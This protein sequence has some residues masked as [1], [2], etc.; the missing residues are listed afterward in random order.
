MYGILEQFFREK[1]FVGLVADPRQKPRVITQI[2]AHRV[3][4]A[5]PGAG[6]INVDLGEVDIAGQIPPAARV[7][8]NGGVILVCS[9][10]IDHPQQ[11]HRSNPHAVSQTQRRRRD[12]LYPLENWFIFFG[13][14]GNLA[15]GKRRLLCLYIGRGRLEPE[16]LLAYL[17][18]LL[19]RPLQIL[20]LDL[21][22]FGILLWQR[23]QAARLELRRNQRNAR[24]KGLR[25]KLIQPQ[26]ARHVKPG[27]MQKYRYQQAGPD[28]FFFQH[29]SNLSVAP[30]LWTVAISVY[31]LTIILRVSFPQ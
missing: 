24:A 2:A 13:T 19:L 3:E 22:R 12:H 21:G 28:D 5:A 10:Q 23:A 8:N 30:S 7:P 14:A 17:R 6:P 26:V 4:R 27:Q 18:R 1:M 16:I 31:L 11:V 15:Q 25:V 9:C 20:H 29:G